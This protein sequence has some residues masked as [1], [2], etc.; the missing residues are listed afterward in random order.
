[1]EGDEPLA[2]RRKDVD[3]VWPGMVFANRLGW[4]PQKTGWRSN[5]GIIVDRDGV[6]WIPQ[7]N[8]GMLRL[9]TSG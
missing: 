3:D 2:G 8:E 5:A 6:C 1:M 7:G 9:K 4:L